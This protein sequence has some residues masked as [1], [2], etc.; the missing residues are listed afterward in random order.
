MPFLAKEQ[1]VLVRLANVPLGNQS[2]LN[3]HEF[4]SYP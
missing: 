1:D 4:V 2:R 3:M